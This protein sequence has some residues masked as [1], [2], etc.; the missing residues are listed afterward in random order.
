MYKILLCCASGLT[1]NMLVNSIK[2][3]A[4]DKKI[5][6][7]CWAVAA[8][9]VELTWADADC[10]LVAPQA[11]S[12]YDKIMNISKGTIPVGMIDGVDFSKM[13]GKEVL[14]QAIELIENK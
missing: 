2:Q 3:E 1:T 5:D 10:I 9:A 14:N 4:K 13:N 6:V 11:R 8:S 7:M 12:D